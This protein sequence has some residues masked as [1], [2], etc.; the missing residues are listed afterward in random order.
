[1]VADGIKHYA[2]TYVTNKYL[3]KVYMNHKMLS[4][5]FDEKKKN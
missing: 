5:R 3:F 2:F 4:Y 1:M